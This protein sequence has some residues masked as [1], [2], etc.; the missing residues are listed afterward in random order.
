[1]KR[2]NNKRIKDIHKSQQQAEEENKKKMACHLGEF[3]K[4][5]RLNRGLTGLRNLGNTCFMNSVL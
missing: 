2:S 5:N 1:M 4:D 3:L